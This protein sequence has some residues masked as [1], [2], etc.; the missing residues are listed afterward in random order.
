MNQLVINKSI[1]N[2]SINKSINRWFR[3]DVLSTKV[4][5]NGHVL[6][7]VKSKGIGVVTIVDDKANVDVERGKKQHLYTRQGQY[8]QKAYP[9]FLVAWN[10]IKMR[11]N[12]TVFV[13]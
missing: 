12:N 5:A 1:V 10:S 2:Q 4:S 11:Y 9:R 13:S 7:T 3:S 6:K 8:W